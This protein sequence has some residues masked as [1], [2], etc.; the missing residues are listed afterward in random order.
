MTEER[1]WLRITMGLLLYSFDDYKLLTWASYH[2]DLQPSII[3]PPSLLCC[4]FYLDKADSPAM[5]KHAMDIFRRVTGY[6][7]PGQIL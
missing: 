4:L 5:I 3:D 7:H 1:L 2:A 6:L